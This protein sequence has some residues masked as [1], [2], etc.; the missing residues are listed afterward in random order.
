MKKKIDNSVQIFGLGITGTDRNRVLRRI[1]LQ[2]K[3]LLHLATVNSEFV[4]QAKDIRKF[5]DAL[6]SAEETVADGYGVVWAAKILHN[7]DL[8]RIT[9]GDLVDEILK[10]CNRRQKKVFLLGAAQGV[11]EKAAREMSKKYPKAK[12]SWYEG[13]KDVKREKREEM[14]LTLAKI[15]AF[16]PDFLLVAYGSPQQDIWIEENR[17]YLRVGMAM[18]VGGVLDEWAGVVKRCPRWIDNAGFKWLWRLLMEP[19]RWERQLNIWKFA[20]LVWWE[21]I[22]MELSDH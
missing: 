11:A 20:A 1:M 6:E 14:G 17:D 4:M 3:N 12:L 16:E 15:N 5:R 13:S 2:R 19:W 8:P 7:I 22:K 18:G 10:E 9:G 21:R